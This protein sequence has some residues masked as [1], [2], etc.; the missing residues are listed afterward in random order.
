MNSDDEDDF[1][2]VGVCHANP[3]TGL[4]AGCGRPL[5]A[6]QAFQDGVAGTASAD[7]TKPIQ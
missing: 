7:S 2:C 6:P 3:A 1:L 5:A 4:C